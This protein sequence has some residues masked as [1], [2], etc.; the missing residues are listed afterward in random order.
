MRDG[1]KRY[2]KVA[3]MDT[4]KYKI[5]LEGLDSPPG[6]ITTRALS[7]LLQQFTAS[8][9]KG[10]RLAIEGQS[11]KVGPA[12]KW[13]EKATDF[14]FTGKNG[15]TILALEAPTLEASIPDL[16]VQQDLWGS[17]PEPHDT[18]ISLIGRSVADMYAE[19]LESD[20]FDYG[21][22]TSITEL[23]PFLSDHAPVISIHCEERPSENF[24]IDIKDIEKVER[25]KIRIPEPRV[26][27][28]SGHLEQV[29]YNSKKFQLYLPDGQ[30]IQG[31]INDEYISIESLR[32]LWGKRVTAR[33]LVSFKPSGKIRIIEAQMLKPMEE[34][35]VLFETAPVI[36]TQFEF[37]KKVQLEA[38]GRNWL[39]EIWNKWPGEESI[40]DIMKEIKNK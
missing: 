24:K 10:L 14:T 22:L 8:A 28:I 7:Q 39:K 18:A 13:L 29:A 25:L 21:V 4:L 1:N 11:T 17:A 19:N 37:A 3:K 16:I 38:T 12:P 26:S 9:E 31:R 30:I 15:S 40:E 33:G 35:E 27:M 36:Q 23:K 5:K 2:D 32:T 34:G 6:T 20:Y